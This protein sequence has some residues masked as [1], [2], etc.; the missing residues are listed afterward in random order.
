MAEVMGVEHV[1][2]GFDFCEFLRGEGDC[3]LRDL[4]DCSQAQTLFDCLERLGMSRRELEL[5]A[6]ENLL[7]V[8]EGIIG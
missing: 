1:C 4:R 6:R 7:R 2:C 8:L 3:N 5:I